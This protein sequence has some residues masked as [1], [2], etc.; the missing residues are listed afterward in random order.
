MEPLLHFTSCSRTRSKCDGGPTFDLP[1]ATFLVLGA[2]QNNSAASG[3]R[4]HLTLGTTTSSTN[5]GDSAKA[6]TTTKSA[7]TTTTSAS[8]HAANDETDYRSNLSSGLLSRG[9]S[10]DLVTLLDRLYQDIGSIVLFSGR[11]LEVLSEFDPDELTYKYD[12]EFLQQIQEAADRHLK[13]KREIRDAL[14]LLKIYHNA[15]KNSKNSSKQS[16]NV[17]ATAGDPNNSVSVRNNS[18]STSKGSPT[19]RKRGHGHGRNVKNK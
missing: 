19:K 11:E 9:Q 6:T 4:I 8:G 5:L 7:S 12:L 3:K 2:Q 15:A 13:E 16:N 10:F 17:V 18:E 1:S 14:G